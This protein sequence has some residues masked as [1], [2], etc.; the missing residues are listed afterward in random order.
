MSGGTHRTHSGQDCQLPNGTGFERGELVPTCW[1]HPADDLEPLPDN[2]EYTEAAIFL[3]QFFAFL[4]AARTMMELA[5][6]TIGLLGLVR[7]DLADQIPLHRALRSKWV[8]KA[9]EEFG[10]IGITLRSE[11]NRKKMRERTAEAWRKRKTPIKEYSP[12]TG[13]SSE[14]PTDQGQTLQ[15]R[16]E[17][18]APSGQGQE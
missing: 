5:S 16:V 7:P 11:L 9:S 3:A 14:S 4:G 13:V 1:H 17:V 15:N 6:R 18:N 2:R 10:L 12:P 8:R